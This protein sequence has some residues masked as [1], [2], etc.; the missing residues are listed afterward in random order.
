MGP[1]NLSS[2]REDNK[3]ARCK[4]VAGS[5]PGRR[6]TFVRAECHRGPLGGRNDMTENLIS[7]PVELERRSQVHETLEHCV[8]GEVV[9]SAILELEHLSGAISAL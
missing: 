6:I 1:R 4:A 7:D 5:L 8:E 3:A 2:K 9:G